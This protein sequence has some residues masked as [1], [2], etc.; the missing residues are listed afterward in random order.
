M[1]VTVVV[2]GQ[3]GS[4]GKGKVAHYL[5]K[6]MNASVAIRCGG[7]NSGH[8]VIDPNG[9]PIIFR[10]LPTASILPDIICVLCAGSYIDPQVLLSEI[11]T[12]GLTP[13]RL[14]I[15][16]NAVIITPAMRELEAKSGLIGSIA[17]TGSGTGEAVIHRIRRRRD[18]AFGKDVPEL[19]PYISDTKAFLRKELLKNRRII[20]EGTQGFGLSLLHSKHY[21]YVTSRDTTAAGFIAE[22]GLSPFDVDD[23]V[24]T[25]RAFP[26]RVGG[27]SGP[28]E[29]ETS[30]GTIARESGS[31][32]YF[33]ETTSVTKN[34]RRVGRFDPDI[35]N[36]SIQSNRPTRIVLNHL[37]YVDISCAGKQAPSEKIKAFIASVEF[38]IKKR[39][40]YLG[41]SPDVLIP[42]KL[43]IKRAFNL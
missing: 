11:E 38:P 29:F 13:A 7:S 1:P 41:F 2:G 3:Y 37:D 20:L 35:V 30:W 6:E 40:D 12:A 43:D 8:T 16:P 36:L 26:I 33:S 23:I 9:N 27:S 4:E 32:S 10:Q 34:L 17:S 24:L 5:A 14:Y 19:R 15:D 25:I 42:R 39:I 21:P 18:L 31:D 22:A 28:L